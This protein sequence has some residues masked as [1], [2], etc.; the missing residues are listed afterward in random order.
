MQ[1]GVTNNAKGVALLHSIDQLPIDSTH[2][3]AIHE[4]DA[5]DTSIEYDAHYAL[6]QVSVVDQ[7]DGTLGFDMTFNGLS[8]PCFVQRVGDGS[9]EGGAGVDCFGQRARSRGAPR[10]S[11]S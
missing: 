1:R 3:Y 6:V 2:L 11:P 9:L 7:G 5:G 4:V 8:C 10:T